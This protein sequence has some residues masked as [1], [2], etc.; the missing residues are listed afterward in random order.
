MPYASSAR[1]GIVL[2]LLLLAGCNQKE[3]ELRLTEKNN[4]L[5][6][7]LRWERTLRNH[8]Q[9]YIDTTLGGGSPAFQQQIQVYKD[10]LTP[11]TVVQFKRDTLRDTIFVEGGK[12]LSRK[13]EVRDI[14]GLEKELTSTLKSLLGSRIR[15][16]RQGNRLSLVIEEKLLFEA[17]KGRLSEGG[18]TFLKKLGGLLS[19]HPEIL[20]TVEG[21]IDNPP[22]Q[23]DKP[24]D[25]W[26]LSL[27]RALSVSEGLLAGKLPAAQIRVAGRGSLQP[28]ADNRTVAGRYLNRRTV[29]YLEPAD[30]D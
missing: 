21:H 9:V 22:L 18:K 13:P 25:S 5:Q 3:K 12:L 19:R 2:F 27:T 28:V 1:W 11:D 24:A 4:R 8:L 15:L 14:A 26:Q 7:T 30:A 29:I 20:V 6:D 23:E 10:M 16:Q 17:E